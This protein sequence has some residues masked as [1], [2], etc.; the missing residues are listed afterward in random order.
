MN[1]DLN[2]CVQMMIPDVYEEVFECVCN[3][4]KV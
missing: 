1:S 3:H 2:V 4:V